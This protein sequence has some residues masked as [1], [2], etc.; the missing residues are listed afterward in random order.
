MEWFLIFAFVGQR[1][2]TNWKTSFRKMED[3]LELHLALF[4]HSRALFVVRCGGVA[5]V[6]SEIQCHFTDTY[7]MVAK[8]HLTVI[9]A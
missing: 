1:F 6:V 5:E 8:E 3:F 2:T 7:C 9:T 4:R